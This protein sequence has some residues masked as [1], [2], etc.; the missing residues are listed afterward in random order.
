MTQIP[1]ETTEVKLIIQVQTKPVLCNELNGQKK[2][3]QDKNVR[4]YVD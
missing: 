2:G 3:F 4:K 1:S